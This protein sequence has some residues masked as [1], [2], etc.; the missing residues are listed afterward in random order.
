M[1]LTNPQ[2]LLQCLENLN[3]HPLVQPHRLWKISL[4]P[5]EV[6]SELFTGP[7]VGAA[8]RLSLGSRGN[9][10][11]PFEVENPPAPQ[12]WALTSVNRLIPRPLV[13]APPQS[14]SVREA[15][16]CYRENFL[17]RP[18][19]PPLAAMPVPP[20]GLD[21][22]EQATLRSAEPGASVNTRKQGASRTPDAAESWLHVFT[23]PRSRFPIYGRLYRRVVPARM[24]M[25][26]DPEQFDSLAV[27]TG[28]TAPL[29]PPRSVAGSLLQAPGRQGRVQVVRLVTE[30]Y[31]VAEMSA[32]EAFLVGNLGLP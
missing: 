14:T 4:I 6:L 17:A 28:P 11:L 12:L 29:Q 9:G 3:R 13:K 5:C 1:P 31:G 23:I 2:D 26:R 8:V 32:L 19:A 25:A 27:V 7:L 20:C 22:P 15:T 24:V 10:T 21:V 16:W 30:S 18:P